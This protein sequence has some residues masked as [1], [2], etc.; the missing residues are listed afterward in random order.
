MTTQTETPMTIAQFIAKHDLR[1]TI[2][3]IPQRTDRCGK[4]TPEEIRWDAEA[5]HWEYTLQIG[6]YDYKGTPR[7]VHKGE[8][9][10]GSAYRRFKKQLGWTGSEYAPEERYVR[11]KLGNPAGKDVPMGWWHNPKGTDRPNLL[12]QYLALVTEGTPPEIADVLDS[13]ASDA[14]TYDGCRDFDDF[15][16]SLGMDPDSRRA[17]AMYK[18]C[19]ET[20]KALRYLLGTEAFETLCNRIERL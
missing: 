9:S 19:G 12:P 18:A 7:M 4:R 8:Y 13:L 14:Q 17:E 16:A 15:C 5:S 1:M 10:R 11:S 2:K 6:P 20:A 3:A